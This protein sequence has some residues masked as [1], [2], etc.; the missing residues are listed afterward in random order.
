MLIDQRVGIRR[1]GRLA[2]D[3]NTSLLGQKRQ[4]CLKT[5]ALVARGQETRLVDRDSKQSVLA[6]RG[7]LSRALHRGIDRQIDGQSGV[8]PGKAQEL[9][10]LELEQQRTCSP[11]VSD[12]LEQL[13][14]TP[15]DMS[16]QTIGLPFR[17]LARA[18][19]MAG[20]SGIVA[21]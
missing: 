3:Q 12:C 11:F 20:T 16:D 15:I 7:N 2:L 14:V 10:L 4:S 17:G 5:E 8:E 13:A 1:R 18:R 21:A 19:F 6:H 9:A